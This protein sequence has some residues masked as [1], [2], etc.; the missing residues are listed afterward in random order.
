MNPVWIGRGFAAAGRSEVHTELYPS[1]IEWATGE[2]LKLS[3]IQLPYMIS[4]LSSWR[5]D[6]AKAYDERASEEPTL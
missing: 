6:S 5:A 1:Q 3:T 4:A 2:R